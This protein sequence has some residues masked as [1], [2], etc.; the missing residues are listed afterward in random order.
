MREGGGI[1]RIDVMRLEPGDKTNRFVEMGSAIGSKCNLFKQLIRM[2]TLFPDIYSFFPPTWNFPDDL[3]HFQERAPKDK[4]YL[5][6]PTVGSQGK[7]IRLAPGPEVGTAY[8]RMCKELPIELESLDT[9]LCSP[10]SSSAGTLNSPQHPKKQGSLHLLPSLKSPSPSRYRAIN[11]D[12]CGARNVHVKRSISFSEH[13]SVQQMRVAQSCI[14][15]IA[16]ASSGPA[17]PPKRVRAR[18]D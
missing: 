3:E 10:S 12:S 16:S 5:L 6:K 7:G 9:G 2:R 13:E 8:G 1:D 18:S 17:L 4:I 11:D 15:H 14:H